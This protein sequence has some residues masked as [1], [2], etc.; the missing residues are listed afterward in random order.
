MGKVVYECGCT[1]GGDLISP[2]CPM[3][4]NSPIVP[5][6][7]LLG[8]P[9]SGARL[10]DEDDLA[11]CVLTQRRAGA[12]HEECLVRGKWVGECQRCEF[13]GHVMVI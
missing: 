12:K 10:S 11:R 13:G 1:A 2:Y 5:T 9:E 7:N 6:P 8:F 3:H 4:P